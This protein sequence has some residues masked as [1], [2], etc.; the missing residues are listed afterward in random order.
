M[1]CINCSHQ[2]TSVVNSRTRKSSAQVWRRRRCSVCHC[3]FT[4]YERVSSTDELLVQN[5]SSSKKVAFNPGKLILSVLNCLNHSKEK[6]E[7]AFWLIETIE[8]QLFKKTNLLVTE[9][10]IASITHQTLASFDKLAGEQY[11]VR[12]RK[13]L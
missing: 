2:K 11:A 7:Q 4:T 13:S 12:H 5:S 1:V 8:N 10:D 9:K 6:A 3:T